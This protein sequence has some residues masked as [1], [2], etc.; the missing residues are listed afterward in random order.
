MT[1]PIHRA[2]SGIIVVADDEAHMSILR[3]ITRHLGF[4]RKVHAPTFEEAE[5]EITKKPPKALIVDVSNVT[6]GKYR[7][8]VEPLIL[9]LPGWIKIFFI[10]K[11]PT[12]ERVKRAKD[13]GVDGI[14]R[15]PISHHGLTTLLEQ[16][17]QA[18]Q[19]EQS[20]AAETT[21]QRIDALIT[22]IA[23]KSDKE[24]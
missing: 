4:N 11:A 15:A 6:S 10:D 13:I 3:R 2:L 1:R 22:D 5:R 21:D 23:E 20:G 16:L 9:A 19:V 12:A 18:P 14:L 7:M 17:D 24:S 8:K